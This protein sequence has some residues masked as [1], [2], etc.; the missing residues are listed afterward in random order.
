MN[1][2]VMKVWEY[3]LKYSMYDEWKKGLMKPNGYRF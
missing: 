3:I 2:N 1:Q